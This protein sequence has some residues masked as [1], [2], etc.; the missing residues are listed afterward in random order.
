LVADQQAVILVKLQ[1]AA[2]AAV[3]AELLRNKFI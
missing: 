3:Q 2:A 1:M